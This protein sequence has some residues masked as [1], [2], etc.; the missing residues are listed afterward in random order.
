[1]VTFLKNAYSVAI[2]QLIPRAEYFFG[3]SMGIP[4]FY[5]TQGFIASHI[6]S[7]SFSLS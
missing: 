3:V 4:S 1:M 2:I 5:G 7:Q 6:K